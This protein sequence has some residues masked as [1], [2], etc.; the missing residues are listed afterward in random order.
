MSAKERVRTYS[1]GVKSPKLASESNPRARSHFGD[2]IDSHPLTDFED[3][4]ED[5]LGDL[6]KSIKKQND[7]LMGK[8]QLTK[9][10]QCSMAS[11]MDLKMGSNIR[12]FPLNEFHTP[13][14]RKL[15]TRTMENDPFSPIKGKNL[16]NTHEIVKN[17]ISESPSKSGKTEDGDCKREE[18][19]EIPHEF[20]I[21]TSNKYS[22][23]TTILEGKNQN[24]GIS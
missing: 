1:N 20:N 17:K 14:V 13:D 5:N 4:S 24:P 19:L 8:I 22:D 10:G 16:L 12:G 3:D 9:Q 18:D 15:K 11:T 23:L 21:S 2:Q 6:L 7:N